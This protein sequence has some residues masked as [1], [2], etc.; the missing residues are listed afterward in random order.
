MHAAC[1]PIL[2]SGQVESPEPNEPEAT[3]TLPQCFHSQCKFVVDISIK[4]F[5]VAVQSTIL[6]NKFFLYGGTL[7]RTGRVMGVH[8]ENVYEIMCKSWYLC[9]DILDL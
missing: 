9:S 5:H 3:P 2:E 1:S 8:T 6:L 4:P 7:A